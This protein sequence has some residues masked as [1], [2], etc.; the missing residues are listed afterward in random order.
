MAEQQI[1]NGRFLALVFCSLLP[2]DGRFIQIN[3]ELPIGKRKREKSNMRVVIFP[4]FKGKNER[5]K[6]ICCQKGQVTVTM[7]RESARFM[8]AK[9]RV[10]LD[11]TWEWVV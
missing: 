2:A 1:M 7:T 6:K 8:M 9:W 3:M 11:A 5:R 4:C 10:V